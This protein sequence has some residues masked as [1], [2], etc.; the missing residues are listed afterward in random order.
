MFFH[1]HEYVQ[2]KIV[3]I[4]GT[5]QIIKIKNNIYT[6]ECRDGCYVHILKLSPN[7]LIKI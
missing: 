3:G 7:K 5:Y 6:V 2:L 4:N 1:L